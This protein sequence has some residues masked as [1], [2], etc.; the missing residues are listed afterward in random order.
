[1]YQDVAQV[2]HV[3]LGQQA[4]LIL[5]APATASFLARFA[6]GIAD[7]LMLNAILASNAPV[8]VCPAMHTEMWLNPATQAN[9]ATLVSRG[10]RVMEPAS[11]RLTGDDS[12]PGRLPEVAEIIEFAIA[13]LPLKGKHVIVTAGGTRE[14]IDS[15]RYIGN[16]SSG[17]MGIELAKAARNAGAQ[18][19]LIAANIDLP[20]PKGIA[21]THVSTV[22]ELELAMDREC[23]VM[24]MAAAVSDFRVQNPFLGKLKRS[25]GLNLELTPTKDLIAN[26]AANHPNSIHI[27]FALAEETK[28]RLIEIARGKLW[29]KSVTAVIGNSFEALGN[30][31][32]LVQFVTKDDAIELSGSK[33]EVSKSILELVS[34]LIR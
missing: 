28:E 25:N 7:D 17:R 21:V 29:D 11:G 9:V 2:R 15:V 30:K 12:G 5:I 14:P 6:A 34:K 18:V 24:I 8:I 31:D 10:V 32:T 26:Y 13:G 33:T 3:E 16:S 19:S 4:D 22:D 27:A 1:M 23:D 20:L